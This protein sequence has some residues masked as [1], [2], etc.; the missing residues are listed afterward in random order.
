M[1]YSIIDNTGG[2][3][4]IILSGSLT[5]QDFLALQGVVKESLEKSGCFRALIELENFQGW[6]KESGWENTAFLMEEENRGSRV[7]F[8]GDEK[9]KDDVFMFTGKPLR[10]IEIE[11]FPSERLAEAQAWLIEPA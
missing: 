4:R 11:Y 6:S 9:W 2:V 5:V 10:A 3:S 7:A 8:V 1:A